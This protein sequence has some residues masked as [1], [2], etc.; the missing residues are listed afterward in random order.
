MRHVSC[1]SSGP[2]G[3]PHDALRTPRRER[4]AESGSWWGVWLGQGRCLQ[5]K[6]PT[7]EGSS[8]LRQRGFDRRGRRERGRVVRTRFAAALILSAAVAALLVG[9]AHRASARPQA[10][11]TPV[12]TGTGGA[13]A[14]V[15]RDATRSAIQ[16]LRAGGNAVD[17]AVAAGATL[18]VTEPYVA[19]IGGGG[20]MTIYLAHG[21]KVITIDGREKAPAAFR[22]DAFI[23]PATGQPYPFSPQR[24]TSGMAVG[25][26]GT[27]ASWDQALQRFGTM[28]FSQVL[29]P[30]I[31]VAESGFVVD[32]TFHDQTESNRTRLQA[33][34]ASRALF[35]P[36]GASPVVGSTFRNPDLAQTY[37]LIAQR[38]AGAFYGGPI[39]SAV[40]DTVVHP[41][42]APDN[43]LGFQ[44]R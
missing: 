12:A 10:A 43:T 34:P 13:A 24:I 30:A 44:V 6:R 28:R 37:R 3:Q 38:G 7:I 16:I 32:Q 20:F 31:G 41:P 14:T 19:G 29:A 17:A 2:F 9:S 4:A 25:V 35:L 15:D 21:H 23:D 39:G 8:Q 18:G 27:L 5:H 1:S 36:G 26:P 40:V 33:F 42:V 22:E 11:G